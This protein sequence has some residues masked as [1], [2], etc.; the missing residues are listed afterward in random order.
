[1]SPRRRLPAGIRGRGAVFTYTVDK[2][3]QTLM[4]QGHRVAGEDRLAKTIIF[5]KN[6]AHAEFIGQRFDLNYPE[7]K[8]AFARV[9]THKTEYAQSLIDDF[10]VHDKAPHI[11]I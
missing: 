1:V 10:S 2:M 9:V 11:A 7:Y 5:G 8:G 6:N 3:L 4:T